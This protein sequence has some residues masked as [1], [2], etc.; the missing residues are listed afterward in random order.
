M[1]LTMQSSYLIFPLV[2]SYLDI[3]IYFFYYLI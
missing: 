3:I 1:L 2:F